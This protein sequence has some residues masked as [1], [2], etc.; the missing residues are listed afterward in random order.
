MADESTQSITIAAPASDV[1]GVIADFEA[2]P[3]W[4][5][6][7]TSATVLTHDD[8]GR[9]EQVR[10]N[11]DA[12]PIKDT[13]VLAYDWVDDGVTWDLVSGQMQRSQRGRYRVADGGDSTEVTY[14]LSVDLAVP[15]PGLLKRRAEKRI[16]DQALTGLKRRVEG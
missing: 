2:Y 3:E 8:E 12:G 10:F 16:M 14:T 4:A 13:Y 1:L 15:L 7:I 6:S 11:L 5:D 9:P